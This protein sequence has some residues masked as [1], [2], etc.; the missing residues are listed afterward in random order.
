M[1]V[2]NTFLRKALEGTAF[3]FFFECSIGM[4]VWVFVDENVVLMMK[5]VKVFIKVWNKVGKEVVF[6]GV[7]MDG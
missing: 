5:V 7:C 2:K 6:M 1:V 3:E 4:N